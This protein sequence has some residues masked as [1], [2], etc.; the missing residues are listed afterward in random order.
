MVSCG[1]LGLDGGASPFQE[2]SPSNS[3]ARRG[4]CYTA[5]QIHERNAPLARSGA[6]SR[7]ATWHENQLVPITRNG[8]LENV[9]W[10]Y[11]YGPIDD[12]TAPNGIGGVL[13]VRKSIGPER[14]PGSLGRPAREVCFGLPNGCSLYTLNGQSRARA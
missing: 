12:E 3:P 13:V 8:A 4:S 7:G 5:G 14:H 9:Y 10:T 6:N 11:S 2:T 1:L